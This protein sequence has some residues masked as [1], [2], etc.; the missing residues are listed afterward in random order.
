MNLSQDK[1]V[2][3]NKQQLIENMASNAEDGTKAEAG[4]YLDSF[5]ASIKDAM[6]AGEEVSL[7]GFGTFKV[8]ERSARVGRNP[9]TG[10]ELQIAASKSPGFKA[11]K[12]LKDACN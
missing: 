10:A 5:M 11:G 3:M 4:K 6:V 9:Q 1:G 7:V 12:P 8:T 2:D